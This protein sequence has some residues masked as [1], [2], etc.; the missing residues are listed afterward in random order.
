MIE[1]E[2]VAFGNIKREIANKYSTALFNASKDKESM[3]VIVT[4]LKSLYDMAENKDINVLINNPLIKKQDKRL[5]FSEIAKQCNWND[6]TLNFLFL[7]IENNRLFALKDIIKEFLTLVESQ[8]GKISVTMISVNEVKDEQQEKIRT[9][10]ENNLGK[11]VKFTHQKNPKILGGLQL[12]IDSLLI[13][14]SLQGKLQRLKNVMKG[15]N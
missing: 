14:G 2:K 13:D 8:D 10:L 4:D 15:V 9:V 11:P 3:D 6:D 5:V 7:L 1:S 12:K